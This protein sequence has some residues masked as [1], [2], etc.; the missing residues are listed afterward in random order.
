MTELTLPTPSLNWPEVTRVGLAELLGALSQA[1]DIT[2]G[3]PAGHCARC[4]LIGT[5]I[6]EALGMEGSELQELYFTLLLTALSD[7]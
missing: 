5:R 3:Q 4:S 2:E 1:L 7:Q 6:G